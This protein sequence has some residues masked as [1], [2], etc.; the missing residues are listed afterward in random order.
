[1]AFV[2]DLDD[3]LPDVFVD[4]QG[5]LIVEFALGYDLDENQVVLFSVTLVPVDDG[6]SDLRFGIRDRH[7]EMDWKISGLYF[8]HERV[9]E[10]IPKQYRPRVTGLLL[11][12]L[13]RLAG[14]CECS[15][16]SMETYYPNLP[17]EAQI[18]KN[19]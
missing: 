2:F 15:H 16:I 9:K 8:S 11:D 5:T 14:A 12:A 3:Q 7:I 1:M 6:V 4:N 17:P 18:H 13:G 10:C 19:R